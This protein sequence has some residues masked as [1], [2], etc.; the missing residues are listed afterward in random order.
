MNS[1]LFQIRWQDVCAEVIFAKKKALPLRSARAQRVREL[2][3]RLA[4]VH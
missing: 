1:E 4:A 2:M 3:I